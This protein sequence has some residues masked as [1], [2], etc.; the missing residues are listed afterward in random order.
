MEG[1]AALFTQRNNLAKTGIVFTVLVRDHRKLDLVATPQVS[2]YG[3][4]FRR[5]EDLE[6]TVHDA[7]DLLE[8]IYPESARRE[9]LHEHVRIELRRFFRHRVSHKPV[10]IPVVIDI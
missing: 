10:V 5:G 7:V 6:S 4:M 3:L 8:E 9:D 2:T 1:T